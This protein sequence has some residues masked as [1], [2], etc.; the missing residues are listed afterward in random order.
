[1][2]TIFFATFLGFLGRSDGVQSQNA[3]FQVPRLSRPHLWQFKAGEAREQRVPAHG[4]RCVVAEKR[5]LGARSRV[6]R[7]DHEVVQARVGLGVALD[8]VRPPRRPDDAQGAAVLDPGQEGAGALREVLA[9]DGVHELA[10]LLELHAVPRRP[11][12]RVERQ[13]HAQDDEALG[14][15]DLARQCFQQ[16]HGQRAPVEDV[17][18]EHD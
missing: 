2:S 12:V 15:G 5:D 6:L 11:H 8:E 14:R 13:A 10:L 9:E 16:G 3:S 18:A 17:E 7:H 4:R 1:M